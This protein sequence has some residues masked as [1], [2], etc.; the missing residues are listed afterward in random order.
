MVVATISLARSEHEA[1][2]LMRSLALLARHADPLIVTD[3]GSVPRFV[4]EI[5]HDPRV[6][7]D[8]A[9][10]LVPQVKSS[11]AAA[12]ATAA[13]R[14]LYTEPDKLEFFETQLS[15]VLECCDSMPADALAIVARSADALATFPARQRHNEQLFNRECEEAFGIVGDYCYGPFVMPG[16]FAKH[17]SA[18]PDDLGWGWRPFVFALGHRLGYSLRMVTGRFDCPADQREEAVRDQAYRDRQLAENLRGLRLGLAATLPMS[19]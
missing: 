13:P 5:A 3:G 14:V 9:I 11:I 17:V 2:L 1:D 12:I 7:V 6:R 18:S 4:R 16:E 10:G 15:G 8:A 19:G